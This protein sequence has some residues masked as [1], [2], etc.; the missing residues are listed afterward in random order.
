ML[1]LVI[2]EGRLTFTIYNVDVNHTCYINELIVDL[3]LF[4]AE[5]GVSDCFELA[6]SI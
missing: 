5:P 3:H 2:F 1:V 6:T 4:T